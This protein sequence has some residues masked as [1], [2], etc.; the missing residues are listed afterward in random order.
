MDKILII[1][2]SGHAKVIIETIE[3]GGDYEI[4]GLIDSFK[5]KGMNVLGYE[6]LGTE[7]NIQDLIDQGISKG[8][9]A[10][11]DNWT[12]LQMMNKIHSLTPDFEFVTVIHP[13][14]IISPSVQIGKGTIIM[15][16]VTINA[17]AKV[18]SHCILNTGAS[19]GHDSVI[20]DFASLAPGVT[21]G[22]NVFIDYCTAIC[23]G[24]NII[25]AINIGKYSIVGAGSIV[26]NDIGDYKL[27]YGLPAK[28]KRDIEKGEQYL[29][30][31]WK[32]S[33]G[34]NKTDK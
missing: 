10:I 5:P 18:G 15:A 12:R 33:K 22:G 16:S 32:S 29:S 17:D 19:F 6:I 2:A 24:A 9:I 3:L 28:E 14:A 31:T 4:Y 26:V 25:Q 11:G 34:K 1:G 7:E 23:L 20:E 8:I 13:S 21:I 30:G 27:A